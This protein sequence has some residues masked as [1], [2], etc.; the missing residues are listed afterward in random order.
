LIQHSEQPV[1]TNGGSIEGR[2]I[3]RTH[4]MTSSLS[5]M[6]TIRLAAGSSVTQR[7]GQRLPH[8]TTRLPSCNDQLSVN[9]AGRSLNARRAQQFRSGKWSRS[10]MG[11]VGRWFL[12]YRSP[13]DLMRLAASAGFCRARHA[14]APTQLGST[15]F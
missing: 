5:D 15:I 13:M 6:R 1:K 10:Y 4:S 14:F 2:K 12:I 3:K 9:V 11:I 7:R 8:M